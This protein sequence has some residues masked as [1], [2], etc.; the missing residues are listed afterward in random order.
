M[1]KRTDAI[2]EKYKDEIVSQ[3]KNRL[4]SDDKIASGSLQKSI[5]GQANKQGINIFSNYYWY[6]VNYGRKPNST[7]PPYRP[8]LEWMKVRGIANEASESKQKKSAYLMA[9]SIGRKGFSGTNFINE[10]IDGLIPA[11]TKDIEES[12]LKDLNDEINGNS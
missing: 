7:P 6:W 9:Q 4:S 5:Y 12:Y 2:L 11:L 8:I 10:V 3:L 1:G